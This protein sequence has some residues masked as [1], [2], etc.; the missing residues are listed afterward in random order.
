MYCGNAQGRISATRQ[1]GFS[2]DKFLM[3]HDREKDADRDVE[4]DIYQRPNDR[5][6]QDRPEE[7]L[8]KNRNILGDA[9][10]PPIANVIKVRV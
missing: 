4:D 1:I 3:Q 5:F 10:Q 6:E 8:L 2:A 9:D 7:L